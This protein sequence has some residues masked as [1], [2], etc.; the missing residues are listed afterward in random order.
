MNWWKL[1]GGRPMRHVEFRF[2]DGIGNEAVSL[3]RDR[4]GRYWLATQRW[5]LFRVPTDT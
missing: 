5:S 3:W 2:Y 4:L 1:T